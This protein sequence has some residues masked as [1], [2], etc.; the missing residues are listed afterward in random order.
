MSETTTSPM[1]AANP[2]PTYYWS[3]TTLA[4]YPSSLEAAYAAANTWPA[5]A[6]PVPQ[7]TFAAFGLTQPPMG[8]QRAAGSD[9]LPTWAAA[10]GS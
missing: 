6:V 10:T 3:K 4:F 1:P 2:Q 8:Q 7:A 5:D 9:G